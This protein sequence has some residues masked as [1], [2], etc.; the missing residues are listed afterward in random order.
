L[1]PK[2]SKTANRITKTIGKVFKKLTIIK[3]LRQLLIFRS[4]MK[5]MIFIMGM[6]Y[7]AFLIYISLAMFGMFDR[8]ITDYYD[9]TNHNYIG[10]CQANI[11]CI[12]PEGNQEKVIE[13]P[14]VLLGDTDVQL[15]GIEPNSELHPL[16][17][18][19]GRKI[20]EKLENGLVITEALHLKSGYDVGDVLTLDFGSNS[21]EIEIVSITEEYT[22]YKA[23]ISREKLSIELTGESDYHN[24]I[25]SSQSLNSNDFA[26]V[27]S[28]EKILNQTQKMQEFMDVMIYILIVISVV[29]GAI[30]VYI[31][32]MMTI[33]DNFYNIS[34]FKVLGYNQK[35]IGQMVLGG[36]SF[37][38]IMVFIV[39]APVSYVIFN[40]ILLFFVREYNVIMPFE[41]GLFHTL[42]GLGIFIILFNIGAWISKKKLNKIS[43]QE[44]MK[45][46]RV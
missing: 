7:A 19:R 21:F 5:F 2:V 14:S 29:I 41:F 38:G 10:Y 33:E 6:F 37:Y 17:S 31:L 30:V 45:M 12:E 36:Y 32:S 18:S 43:L 16:Y 24:V 13:L 40:Y 25:F 44:A 1:N 4:F 34:L 8:M 27:V 22:G 20:T 3:K 11:E 39:T 42:I 28:T 46:Y 9:Q 26:L 23:Y 35:E 15:I